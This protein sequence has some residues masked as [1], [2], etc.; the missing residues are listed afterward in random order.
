MDISKQWVYRI[1]PIN[2]LEK[3]ITNGLFSKNSAPIDENRVVIG[4]SE[5]INE[6]DNRTVR[7]FPETVVNDYVPFYFS[8]RTPMLYNIITGYGVPTK[9]QEDIIYL[10]CKLQD[11][12]NGNFQWCFTDGNA[13]KIITKFYDAIDQLDELDWK[14]INTEDFRTDNSDGNEDRIRQKHSEF[15]ILNHVPAS[16]IKAVVVLNSNAEKRV[17]AILDTCQVSLNVYINPKKK[18]YFL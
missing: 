3:D 12:A 17:K 7:C 13:A 2:N 16:K 10:C 6:R 1:I 8:V 15:L 4:N 11:L 18:F 5:I 9:P 14:S